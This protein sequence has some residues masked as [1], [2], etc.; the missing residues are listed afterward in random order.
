MVEPVWLCPA[1]T[2]LISL[3][4]EYTAMFRCTLR[5]LA[6]LLACFTLITGCS[7]KP[8]APSKKPPAPPSTVSAPA[9]KP[10]P[11]P[12]HAITD[13]WRLSEEG[14]VCVLESSSLK[15][16]DGYTESEVRLQVS[17]HVLRALTGATIDL[18][19]DDTGLRV[20]HNP[21]IAIEAVEDDTN[22]RFAG[23]FDEV[24]QQFIRG[25]H[26]ELR[27]RFWPTWPSKGT[28]ST[29]FSLAGFTHVWQ[30][31]NACR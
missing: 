21:I 19:G 24:V 27:L 25:G 16:D 1:S 9:T 31:F 18:S 10:S 23:D 17:G 2:P 13:N 3:P 7:D 4:T 29:N 12:V 26:A 28:R 20:D 8:V 5:L 22:V 30:A 14:G 6:G 11:A 15:L